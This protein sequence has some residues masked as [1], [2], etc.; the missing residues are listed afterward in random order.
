MLWQIQIVVDAAPLDLVAIGGSN[1]TANPMNPITIGVTKLDG[2]TDWTPLGIQSIV[3]VRRVKTLPF[4]MCPHCQRLRMFLFSFCRLAKPVPRKPAKL[5]PR[6][7]PVI[8]LREARFNF[9]L[10]STFQRSLCSRERYE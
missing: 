6:L 1:Q 9:R 5:L 10:L 7:L 4:T 3:W 8:M 2:A